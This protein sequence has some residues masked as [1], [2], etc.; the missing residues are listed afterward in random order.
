M[1]CMKVYI[2]VVYSNRTV[3]NGP[4]YAIYAIKVATLIEQSE[5]ICLLL[6]IQANIVI[7][8][9]TVLLEY[10]KYQGANMVIK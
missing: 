4:E 3:R 2:M 1:D 8:L 5:I 9:L 7:L 10:I 6:E